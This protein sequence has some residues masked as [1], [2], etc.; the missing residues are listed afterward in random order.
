MS[1]QYMG[2]LGHT[3]QI[4]RIKG[5]G[6]EFSI[7]RKRQAAKGRRSCST[8]IWLIKRF[9]ETGLLLKGRIT[10]MALEE[11]EPLTDT[12]KLTWCEALLRDARQR[13]TGHETPELA[14][15]TSCGSEPVGDMLAGLEREGLK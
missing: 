11:L 8:R 10:A 14:H 1:E 5:E 2:N 9:Y 7:Y 13:S 15:P 4:D 3:E 6:Y 12:E